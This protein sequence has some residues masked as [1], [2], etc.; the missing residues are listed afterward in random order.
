MDKLNKKTIIIGIVVAILIVAGIVALA[1]FNSKGK[2]TTEKDLEAVTTLFETRIFGMTTHYPTQY[3]GTEKLYEADET[4]YE[5][6]HRN[7]VLNVA[8]N[9]ANDHEGT[10]TSNNMI[11]QLEKMGY[12]SEDYIVALDG[13]VMTEGVEKIFGKELTPGSGNNDNTFGFDFIY[14]PTLNV[15]LKVKSSAN[16]PTDGTHYVDYK[17][18]ESKTKD[19]KVNMTIANAYVHIIGNKVVY[20]SDKEA[21]K[22][23]YDTTTDDKNGIK[24][25]YL[26][27]FQKY[28]VTFNYDE[29]TKEFTFDSIKKEK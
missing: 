16:F 12:K 2:D 17:I 6:L 7:V 4:K 11:Q 5:D 22:D 18:I 27:K 29:E 21:S 24:D 28:T 25:E 13:A 26:D 1:L 19:N 3:K 8:S 9:Y 15:Y 20:T 10:I 14:V 23:I